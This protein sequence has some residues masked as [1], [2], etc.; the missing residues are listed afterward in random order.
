MGTEP[1]RSRGVV[2]SRPHSGDTVLHVTALEQIEQVVD[3]SRGKLSR[4]PTHGAAGAQHRARQE[5][6][7]RSLGALT[8]WRRL[9]SF[10]NFGDPALILDTLDVP[11]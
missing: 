7:A 10:I 8:S 6:G 4:S 2:L 1:A 11:A 9:R 5:A 3:R